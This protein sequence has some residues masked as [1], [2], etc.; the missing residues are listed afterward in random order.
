MNEII[1]LRNS[2]IVNG[3]HDVENHWTTG[4][5]SYLKVKNTA[6]EKEFYLSHECRTE[7]VALSESNYHE[8]K[9]IF[10]QRLTGGG[11]EWLTITQDDKFYSY[12]NPDTIYGK[13]V[14]QKLLEN[15]LFIDIG[16]KVYAPNNPRSSTEWAS[17]VFPRYSRIRSHRL[18][19]LNEMLNSRKA[20]PRK[21]FCRLN[22]STNGLT[23]TCIFPSR[24]VNYKNKTENLNSDKGYIQV[25]SGYTMIW[26]NS[27]P[28]VG[29]L[30]VAV[31]VNA[32][33]PPI[34]ECI[35]KVYI[36]IGDTVTPCYQRV[37]T[38]DGNIDFFS[39]L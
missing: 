39:Y 34:I 5:E 24:Y 31:P 13:N 19:E 10:K 11:G 16:G 32:N 12:T 29:Y 1:D 3:R 6:L 2:Y 17:Q 20:N 27:S 23:V 4:V 38:I 28:L 37:L 21:L 25:I 8:E 35:S 33:N 22:Y 36:E 9:T 14:F 7:D 15:S 26:N 18:D 30:A